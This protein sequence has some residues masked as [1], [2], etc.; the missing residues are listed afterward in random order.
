MLLHG[1]ISE[2][3]NGFARVDLQAEG[4]VTNWLPIMYPSSDGVHVV[5]KLAVNTPVSVLMD[6]NCE[7]GVVLGA[8][9]ENGFPTTDADYLIETQGA[10]YAQ[11]NGLHRIKTDTENMKT[12]LTDLLVA[13]ET[14]TFSAF[15]APPNNAPI[16]TAIKTRISLLLTE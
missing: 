9:F 7:N 16:F 15:G 13:L 2:T 10:E 6:S 4:I 11:E 8:S 14:C 3:R 1:I 12:L 5:A